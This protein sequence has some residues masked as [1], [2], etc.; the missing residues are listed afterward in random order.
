[1]TITMSSQY[2][3][4]IRAAVA[5]RTGEIRVDCPACE[6]SQRGT[7]SVNA[8]TG[9]YRC[10]RC[11]LKGS[12]KTLQD[13]K[14]PL[15]EYLWER[16]CVSIAK[17]P[18]LDAKDVKSYG[19][20]MDQYHNIVIPLFK[21]DGL[22]TL[23]FIKP[24]GEK[25]LLSKAKGGIKKGSYFQVGNG[26]G[27]KVYICEGYA[28]AASVYEAVG[29]IVYMAVDAGNLEPAAK[30]IKKLHKEKA[31]VFCADNDPTGKG[32]RCACEAARAVGGLVCMPKQVGKDINDIYREQG[33]EAVKA[34]LASAAL[35]AAEPPK[36]AAE[37]EEI[38]AGP[39][40]DMLSKKHA[41]MM[42]GGKC[43]VLN[44]FIEPVFGRPDV[45]FSSVADFKNYY[46][47]EVYFVWDEHK[48]KNAWQ[49]L[50]RI[51]MESPGRREYSGI[52]FE[53]AGAPKNF[54]NLW[55]GF[56]VE[57][58]HGD[59][60]MMRDHLY[61][62]ICNC[63]D[64]YMDW[65]M[66]WMANLVQNPGGERPGVSIVLR[67]KRGTGKGAFVSNF[68]RI[69]GSHFLQVT[70]SKHLVGHFNSHLKDCLLLFLDEAFWAGDKSVEGILKGLI[71]EP[72]VTIEPKG[73]DAFQIKN[74]LS[75]IMASNNDWVVPAGLEERR[76]FVLDVSDRR[77]GDRAYFNELFASMDNGGVEAMLYDLLAYPINKDL[78]TAP[79]T[80]ALLDQIAES[81]DTIQ[82]WWFDCL[83]AGCID[84]DMGDWPESIATDAAY[85]HYIRYAE[86]RGYRFRESEDSFGKQLKSMC[87]EIS[88]KRLRVT[89]SRRHHYF[90]PYLERSRELFSECLGMTI[91]W[92][93][94]DD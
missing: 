37:A 28:T 47:N 72:L 39:F 32:Y 41:V 86:K 55:R 73:K 87:P 69:F 78:R 38:D 77:I 1:M 50:G 60:S 89:D 22:S 54:Y 70:N 76:F 82:A 53:P 9:Q 2:I 49:T 62:V 81:F 83:N 65:L 93:D 94:G 23:Q 75:F 19:L 15:K 66:S 40:V 24:D 84:R 7:L 61:E 4:T 29:G 33:P 91:Q 36:D 34:I 25:L 59:W 46:T 8:D 74:H 58:K 26:G 13:E 18:Y 51:F 71:T 43:V 42:L 92:D 48:Q 79:R 21:N 85:N 52:V 17:H 30:G 16:R 68:G 80:A 10:F 56:A 67:G 57:P 45:S 6:G 3:D 35:P 88:K 64:A 5:G 63:N 27:D 12:L 44:E 31:F 20:K 90:F 14:L 11:D